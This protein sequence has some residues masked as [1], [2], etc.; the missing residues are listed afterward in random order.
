MGIEMNCPQCKKPMKEKRYFIFNTFFSDLH[1][2][3][4]M[5]AFL[6]VPVLM[7]GIIG[8][9]ILLVLIISGIVYCWDKRWYRCKECDC[10]T[11]K[12]LKSIQP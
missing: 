5:L 2:F 3:E 1:L 10:T 8:W 12:K 11:V 4:V 9:S 7:A 6:I